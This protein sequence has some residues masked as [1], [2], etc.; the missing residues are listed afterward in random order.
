MRA[1]SGQDNPDVRAVV[2][3]A[4]LY[5]SLGDADSALASL[6]SF[7]Q[8]L[9]N[10]PDFLLAFMNTAYAA[11]NEEAAHEA[12]KAL[13]NLRKTGGVE[14][15]AFRMIPADEG[16]EMLKTSMKRAQEKREHLHSEMLRGQMPWVWVEQV[17]GNAI[18]W[19]W[20]RRTQEIAWIGDDPVDRKSVV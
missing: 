7:R 2:G 8:V 1:D 13:D 15:D 16:L 10:N 18:Y 17:A 20:R 5:L 9:W 14:A 11:G 12:F 4:E 6:Q 19:G 3:R